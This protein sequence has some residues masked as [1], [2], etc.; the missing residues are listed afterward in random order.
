MNYTLAVDNDFDP[1]GLN[2]EKR[3][4]ASMISNPLFI[5]VALSMVIFGPIF[6]VGCASA[7]FE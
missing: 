2:A 5:S 4:T 7:P 3:R 6:H 1:L